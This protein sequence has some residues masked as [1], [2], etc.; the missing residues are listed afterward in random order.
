M[1]KGPL[2][3]YPEDCID[4]SVLKMMSG[5]VWLMTWM[6]VVVAEVGWVVRP[7]CA[8]A[9]VLAPNILC[10]WG[11]PHPQGVRK[12]NEDEEIWI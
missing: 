1:F 5:W 6:V 7:C 10:G 11:C 8:L 4:F 2:P 12:A 3:P 9:V